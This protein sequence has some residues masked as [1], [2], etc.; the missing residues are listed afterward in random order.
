[1]ADQNKQDADWQCLVEQAIASAWELVGVA[2]LVVLED[3]QYLDHEGH[4]R[5][6]THDQEAVVTRS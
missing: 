5:Q 2:Y 4:E 3:D 1:M 6:T